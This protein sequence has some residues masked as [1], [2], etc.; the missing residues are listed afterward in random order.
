MPTIS[1]F[2]GI[3]I[4]M[5]SGQREHLPSHFHASYG[6]FTA[7]FDIM[8]GELIDGG[9]PLPQRRLISAW[10]EIHRDELLADWA[11]AQSREALFRIDP[12]K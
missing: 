11:L 1:M 12:L 5:Y 3:L 10:G 2:Y 4:R 8:N 7:T 6:E 9:M